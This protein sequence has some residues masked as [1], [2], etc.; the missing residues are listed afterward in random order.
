MRRAVLLE[1]PGDRPVAA[2][3]DL[4]GAHRLEEAVGGQADRAAH[5]AL[6]GAARHEVELAE[7]E[8]ARAHGPQR[9][10]DP[11]A[12]PVRRPVQERL[13]PAQVAVAEERLAEA[14]QQ[15]VLEVEEPAD[16]ARHLPDELARDHRRRGGGAADGH[17]DVAGGLAVAEDDDVAVA[18]LLGVVQLGGRQD[19]PAGGGELRDAGQVGH[20][21]LAED[22]VGDDEVVD[23]LA[24]RVRAGGGEHPAGVAPLDGRH[25]GLQAQQPVDAGVRGVRREVGLHLLARRPL[26]VVGGHREVRERVRVAR[27]LRRQPRVATG[28]APDAPDVGRAVVDDDVMADLGED[29]RGDEPG[30]PGADDP[31]PHDGLPAGRRSS[32]PKSAMIACSTEMS[33]GPGGRSASAW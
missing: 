11:P 30:D 12:H 22:A 25:L 20:G 1:Q 19:P 4:P 2:H 5:D 13:D 9:V 33:F 28:R 29:L 7:P 24:A 23:L 18:G 15:Q 14:G 17:G 21:R 3:L 31:D 8:L 6:E 10:E 27:A 26:G 32:I 16:P